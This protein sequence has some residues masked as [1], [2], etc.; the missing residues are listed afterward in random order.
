MNA[1]EKLSCKYCN[2]I[3]KAPIT[4][5]CC[6]GNICKQH[7]DEFIA[8]NS[9]NNFLCPLCHNQ[10]SNQNLNINQLIQDLVENGLPDFEVDSKFKIIFEN[11]KTEIQNLETVLKDPENVIYDEINELK[12]QVDLEKERLK[13]EID[14]MAS[15][16]IQQLE[17]YEARFKTEYKTNVDFEHYNA[18]VES[19]RKQLEEYENCLNLFSAKYKE[20]K[21]KGT[22]KK[23]LVKSLQS[24]IVELKN[25]LFSNLSIS[26]KPIG[27][28]ANNS[29]GKLIIKVS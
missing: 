25:K 15:D 19:S 26:F 3:Y 10:N 21:E 24:E 13:I 18:L 11:L 8:T 6:G 4:L 22:Q 14:T 23:K 28:K 17:S 27:G 5:T 7:I 29:L 12:R 16:L 20:Q 1:R 2:Q 9:S